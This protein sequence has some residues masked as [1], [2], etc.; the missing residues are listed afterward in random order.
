M[1]EEEKNQVE[2]NKR[3]F[4]AEV[5]NI[6]REFQAREQASFKRRKQ[7]N[8]GVLVSIELNPLLSLL[9]CHAALF[10]PVLCWA[11]KTEYVHHYLHVYCFLFLDLVVKK[12]LLFAVLIK[13]IA[14]FCCM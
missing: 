1:E 8:D 12:Y 2:M 9:F 5:L 7:R 3:K 13:M 6:A 11:L 10:V 4:F 14:V